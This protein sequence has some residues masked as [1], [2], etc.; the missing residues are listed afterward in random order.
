MDSSDQ[1]L[2][3][4]LGQSFGQSSHRLPV[5]IVPGFHDA[6][7]TRQWVRSLPSFVRPLIIDAYPTS[8]LAVYEWLQA[9]FSSDPNEPAAPIV[10]IAF[11]AGVIGLAG[12]LVLFNQ[13]SGGSAKRL[14]AV[15]GFGVPVVG[16]PVTRISH[17]RFTHASSLPLG[18]GDVNFYADPAVD[19]LQLWGA[20]EAASGL[21]VQGWNLDQGVPMTAAEFLRRVLHAEWN[22]AF[23][24][25]AMV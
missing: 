25:R 17:D 8:P 3:Q 21:E 13:S 19:H 20:P 15:D 22:K 10:G 18:A 1:V 14:I 23:S 12:G 16:V 24:W 9:H 4:S 6:A 11:S 7:L 2:G 5:V